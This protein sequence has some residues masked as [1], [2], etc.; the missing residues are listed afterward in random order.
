M[1]KTLSFRN[2]VMIGS[3]QKRRCQKWFSFF[4]QNISLT[5]ILPPLSRL[6]ALHKSAWI[7][8]VF[9]SKLADLFRDKN[10]RDHI[11]LM[12]GIIRKNDPIFALTGRNAI[13][14]KTRR[15]LH[16]LCKW[17][18]WGAQVRVKIAQDLSIWHCC[19]PAPPEISNFARCQI[20]P[21]FLTTITKNGRCLH[22]SFPPVMTTIPFWVLPW[23]KIKQILLLYHYK[24]RP[25]SRLYL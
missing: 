17:E 10:K 5:H 1:T 13:L 24:A 4:S 2:R 21:P 20:V 6:P 3:F 11:N 22:F 7:C 18:G 25:L 15:K 9:L 8:Q 19:V 14:I 23:K 12:R 16:C